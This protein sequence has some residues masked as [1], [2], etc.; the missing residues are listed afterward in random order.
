MRRIIMSV[1]VL[2]AVWLLMADSASAGRRHRAF[3]LRSVSCVVRARAAI[4][5]ACN[6]CNS[7]CE[8]GAAA[9]SD[10]L[11]SAGR[12][13]ASR[14]RAASRVSRMS[15][16]MVKPGLQAAHPEVP[17]APSAGRSSM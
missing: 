16:A 5:D 7:C 12:L 11:L 4:R 3:L 8:C 14:R 15:S 13:A 1:A 17:K 9:T 2:L 10:E 6:T